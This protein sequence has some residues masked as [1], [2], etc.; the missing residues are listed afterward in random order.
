MIGKIIAITHLLIAFF[1]SFYAFI[2][3]KNALYDYI[4]I[5]AL[6]LLQLTW[7]L[8]KGECPFS[9][10]YKKYYYD[11]YKLGHTT[12][13]DDFNELNFLSSS[14]ETTTET[15]FLTKIVNSIFCIA[16]ILSIIIVAFRSR[17][18]NPYLIIFICILLRFFYLFFNDATG[19]DTNSIGKFV[20]GEN[21]SV[22]ENSYYRFKLDTLHTEINTG[23]SFILLIFL[24]YISYDNQRLLHI[25]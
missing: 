6:V 19:Y 3:P 9:Y 1:L 7:I 4:Y 5:F 24:G 25:K 11:N 14:N 17:I 10:F 15:S 12:T 2:V 21:Y 16:I 18:V 22:F 23:I 13:T 20:L 8:F